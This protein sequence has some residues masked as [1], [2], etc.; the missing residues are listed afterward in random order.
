MRVGRTPRFVFVLLGTVIDVTVGGE[1]PL[2]LYIRSRLVDRR[3]PPRFRWAWPLA[4][5]AETM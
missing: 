5:R 1:A 4:D 2:Y 3:R